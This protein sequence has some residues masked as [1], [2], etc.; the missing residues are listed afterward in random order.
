MPQHKLANVLL[1]DS[2]QFYRAPAIYCNAN[3]PI[4]PP[5]GFQSNWTLTG[6]G[7]FDFTTFFNA[8]PTSKWLRYT[9]ARDFFLHLELRGA[10]C[11]YVQTRAD[12]YTWTAEQLE[13]TRREI[14]AN[15]AWTILDIPLQLNRDVLVGF[16]LE[17]QGEIFIRNSFYYTKL[18]EESIK[19]VELALCT[20]TFKN[21]NYILPNIELIKKRIIQADEPIA[22][23]FTLHVI[24]NGRTLNAQ[25]LEEARI[26]VH[27]NPNAGGA[28][29]FARGMI[30]AMEQEPKATHV[31]LMDDDVNVS[32]ESILRSYSLL[33]I[34]NDEY[35]EA[36]LSGA[37]M[38]L[39]VPNIRFEDVGFVASE[40]KYFPMKREA[41]VDTLHDC[42][43]NEAYLIPEVD[44]PYMADRATQA[45][46]AW[47]YCVIPMTVIERNGMP[48]PI[49]VRTDDV[50][51]SLRA[52]AK[53]MTMNGIC[54]WHSPFGK[55]YSAAVERYQM[56]RNVLIGRFASG[57]APMSDFIGSIERAFELELKK[58]NYANAELVLDGFEDFLKG[59]SFIAEP[60]ASEAA[61]L[62][63]LKSAEQLIPLEELR[64]QAL[65]LGVDLDE[66]STLAFDDEDFDVDHRGFRNRFED[67]VSVNGHK[68]IHN[69]YTQ[70]GSVGIIHASGWLYPVDRIRKKEYL[71]A[72]DPIQKK[73]IIRR[74]DREK[75]K[76]LQ[77]R[78]H[79]D[80]L[81][82]R[83]NKDRLKKEYEESREKLTSVAFWKHY[84][85]IE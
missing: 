57:M 63:H 82:Y 65:E 74:I 5:R 75:F 4:I 49:F 48:L 79:R 39:D 38:S 25:A 59:P 64:E 73:G 18:E 9:N 13:G 19:T 85:G 33:Q 21:E 28:G 27:P 40:G 76:Q 67:N 22:Q 10:A 31:L 17:A 43:V 66:V 3:A 15:D 36:F 83:T 81:E 56:T 72:I 35:V 6:P 12:S 30:E 44:E 80:M 32:P 55:R 41:Y 70:P 69:R 8:L 26:H 60:G 42:I 78:F 34:V 84:L 58:F 14:P 7:C 37:M 2:W 53:L 29:G 24:D 71:I 46:A 23:H 50:E 68:F 47:W 45:Y 62:S 54:V 52:Q 11:T 16:M 20:T 61:Y 51:Y 1:E 77:D